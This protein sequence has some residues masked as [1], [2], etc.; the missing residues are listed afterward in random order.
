MSASAWMWIVFNV[1]VAGLIFVDLRVLNRRAH[2]VSVKEAALWSAGWIGLA[3]LFNL[4]V[5]FVL[6]PQKALEFLTGYVIE[7][8]LSVDNMFVFIMIFSYFKVKPLY[9][10]RVL[11]WGILGA[12]VMRFVLILAGVALIKTFHWIIYLFGVLLIFTAVKMIM[13]EDRKIEPDKNPVLR[14]FKRF[15]PFTTIEAEDDLFVKERGR[16]KATALFAALLVVEASDLVFAVDSIPAVLAVTTDTF[17]VYT[18]N[19]FAIMG[20]RALYFL[21]AG[22]VTTFRF[23]KAGISVVL[24]YV[25]IKMVLVDVFPIPVSVSLGVVAGILAVS[26]AASVVLPARKLKESVAE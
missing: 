21:L 8:A 5:Y 7:K 3:L 17:I 24:G 25:G 9:Q 4:G 19:V 13:E 10:A 14:L 26:V 16:W 1:L 15:L 22:V 12:L 20:L 23:L 18:S 2:V 6:G 11:R